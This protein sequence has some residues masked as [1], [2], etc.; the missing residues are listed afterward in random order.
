MP[1]HLAIAQFGT[2]SALYPALPLLS[3]CIL[4]EPK[5]SCG[6]AAGDF[7]HF[8]KACLAFP[9]HIASR[10]EYALPMEAVAAK[11]CFVTAFLESMRPGHPPDIRPASFRSGTWRRRDG[12][13]PVRTPSALLPGSRT[14]SAPGCGDLRSTRLRQS[15]AS[16]SAWRRPS[17]SDSTSFH[18]RRPDASPW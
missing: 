11:S 13:C 7:F 18:R 4:T 9:R 8:L 2:T 3:R 6:S 12:S 15:P 16:R 10:R 1:Y 5:I 17:G 14:R